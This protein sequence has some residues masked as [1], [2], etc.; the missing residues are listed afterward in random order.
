VRDGLPDERVGIRHSDHMLGWHLGRV[1]ETA[2]TAGKSGPV[3]G[4][5][6]VPFTWLGCPSSSLT[7]RGHLRQPA[8]HFIF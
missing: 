8:S 5:R 3:Q 6:P 4:S 7:A 1:N 2:R